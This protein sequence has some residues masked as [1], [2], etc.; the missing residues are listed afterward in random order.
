MRK[1]Y[2]APDAGAASPTRAALPADKAVL[3]EK[4]LA[5]YQK[6]SP[7]DID[8]VDKALQLKVSEDELW[9]H[10]R[11]KYNAP[12][13]TAASGTMPAMSLEKAA[14]REKLVAFYQKYNPADLDKV[15][16][17]VNLNVSEEELWAHLHKKYNVNAVKASITPVR[18]A[19]QVA[20]PDTAALR[21]KLV[22][23]YTKHSPGELDKVDKALSLNVSEEEL[24][25]HLRKKY[26]VAA[27]SANAPADKGALRDKLVAFYQKYS[28]S[29]IDKVDKALQLNV[30]E[31]DLWAHLKKKYNVL[32][33]AQPPTPVSSL[34]ADEDPATRE[35]REMVTAFYRQY[36]PAELGKVERAIRLPLS[37]DE[38]I[39]RLR[40]KYNADAPSQNLDGKSAVPASPPSPA[41]TPRSAN[42]APIPIPPVPSDTGAHPARRQSVVES[43][44]PGTGAVPGEPSAVVTSEPEAIQP[45]VRPV[46]APRHPETIAPSASPPR[47]ASHSTIQGLDASPPELRGRACTVAAVQTHGPSTLHASVQCE[48]S[49]SD[50]I[51]LSSDIISTL[52]SRMGDDPD[53][54]KV[55]LQRSLARAAKAEYLVDTLASR[56]DALRC[57]EIALS[58]REASFC[59]LSKIPERQAGGSGP[60]S[61]RA[62]AGGAATRIDPSTS[63]Y[64][65]ALVDLEEQLLIEVDHTRLISEELAERQRSL[66]AQ[67]DRLERHR[68]ETEE[69]MRRS[70][71][72]FRRQQTTVAEQAAVF[73]ERQS[74]A[75]LELRRLQE[76]ENLLSRRMEAVAVREAELAGEKKDLELRDRGLKTQI[77]GVGK[78]R[79]VCRK[80]SDEV[81]RREAGVRLAEKALNSAREELSRLE[82][83]I[84]VRVKKVV[85]DE[86]ALKRWADELS[87]QDME[88]NVRRRNS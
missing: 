28:P 49:S 81:L 84:T 4:L 1:K 21:E 63:A 73:Q 5:F 18:A 45:P 72:D 16:K 54:L 71:D 39:A 48:A 46:E 83:V 64:Y 15:E 30:S 82:T 17:A 67:R 52:V 70:E 9:A 37:N 56:E 24:W 85:Q 40:A 79:D 68:L 78:E 57:R 22:A 86:A 36:C 34:G 42:S 69:R 53:E 3:R 11:K 35:R 29:E 25:G 7:A 20:V 76:L 8:K 74:N 10:L 41:E 80:V 6:Y 2:N 88:L 75:D 33:A 65:A 87:K 44:T 50:V 55:A 43:P 62:T 47:R 26:N 58:A 60:L 23:F 38:L 14:L 13:V 66:E 59:A 61:F 51:P 12:D 77:E 19:S 32:D 31:D 27:D